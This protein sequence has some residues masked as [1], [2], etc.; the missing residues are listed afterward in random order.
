MANQY[1]RASRLDKV[2][3]EIRF[4]AFLITNTADGF[5]SFE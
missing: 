3:Q 5:F 1:L 2:A 4:V